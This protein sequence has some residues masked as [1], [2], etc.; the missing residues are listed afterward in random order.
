MSVYTSIE[1]RDRIRAVLEPLWLARQQA[2]FALGNNPAPEEKADR[3][4][5]FGEA[6][7][8]G[9]ALDALAEAFGFDTQAGPPRPELADEHPT[10]VSYCSPVAARR[11][12]AN[13][14]R[15]VRQAG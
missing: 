14:G 3:A 15:H 5:Y 8:V 1:V 6:H 7:G 10:P 13:Q 4:F 2:A 12:V 9:A 11:M